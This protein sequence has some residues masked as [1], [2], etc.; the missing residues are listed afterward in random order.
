MASILVIEDDLLV[1][2]SVVNA[3]MR[4]GYDVRAASHGVEGL[5]LYR[6]QAADLVIT[7]LVMPEQ[8]GI[9]TIM[10]LHQISPD[11]RIIAMSGGMVQNPNLYLQLAEKL[12]ANRVLRKPFLL[13]ELFTVVAEVLALPRP[14]APP[15]GS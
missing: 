1:R 12:G 3:L 4:R 6:A 13:Q 7:D 5:R 8:D 9:S 10:A 2:D 11:V 15:S 14:P